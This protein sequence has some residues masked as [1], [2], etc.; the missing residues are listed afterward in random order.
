MSK[1]EVG[2]R[3]RVS[4]GRNAGQVGQVTHFN[5]DNTVVYVDFNRMINVNEG[6]GSYD[7][8]PDGYWVA[9]RTVSSV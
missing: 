8:Y 5:D 9:I 3:V 2:T 4:T 7:M 1:I 6:F